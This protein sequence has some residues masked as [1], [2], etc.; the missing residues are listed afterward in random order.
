MCICFQGGVYAFASRVGL[1]AFAARVGVH[2]FASAEDVVAALGSSAG[3]VL[4]CGS[5]GDAGASN[6]A[7]SN[8]L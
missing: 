4:C 8:V 7:E 3:V 1:Y 2:P 6:I 5:L